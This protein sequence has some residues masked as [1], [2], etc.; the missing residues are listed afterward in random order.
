M[1]GFGFLLARVW[2]WVLRMFSGVFVFGDFG[3]LLILVVYGVWVG[4]RQIFFEI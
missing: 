2:I 1:F 3:D 4:I